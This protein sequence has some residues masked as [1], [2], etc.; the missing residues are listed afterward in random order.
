VIFDSFGDSSLNFRLL[1][2]VRNMADRLP[3]I[4]GMHEAIDQAFRRN[5]VQIPFPQ[6]DLHLRTVDG[7]VMAAVARNGKG[8]SSGRARDGNGAGEPSPASQEPQPPQ[9]PQAAPQRGV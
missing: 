3:V 4:N 2:F 9:P 1:V 6:R 5:G 8:D 7:E